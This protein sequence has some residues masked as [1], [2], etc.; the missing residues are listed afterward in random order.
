[1]EQFERLVRSV[2]RSA[3][4]VIPAA[5]DARKQKLKEFAVVTEAEKVEQLVVMAKRLDDAER[6]KRVLD[7]LAA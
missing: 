4:E 5:D 1:M 6:R 3:V 2:L 7:S